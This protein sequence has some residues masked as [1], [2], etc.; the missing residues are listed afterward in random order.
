MPEVNLSAEEL[1]LLHRALATF[2]ESGSSGNQ[3]CECRALYERVHRILSWGTGYHL[4]CRQNRAG[5]PQ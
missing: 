1:Q 2:I 3:D 4:P 5:L